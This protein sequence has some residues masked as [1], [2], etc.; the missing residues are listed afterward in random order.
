MEPEQ[1]PVVSSANLER[2]RLEAQFKSGSGWFFWIAGLSIVNSILLRAG[3]GIQF[4]FAL[5]VPQLVD[6][7]IQGATEEG[8]EATSLLRLIGFGINLGLCGTFALFGCFARKRIT[9]VYI[10]GMVVYALDGV[11]VLL[12]ALLLG[13]TELYLDFGFHVLALFFLFGG[14]KAGFQLAALDRAAPVPPPGVPPQAW[15]DPSQR[16]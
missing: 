12:I 11:V 3:V 9:W 16:P 1:Q 2:L 14:L 5:G 4:I 8:G 15:T 6:I 13:V 10:V 7:L